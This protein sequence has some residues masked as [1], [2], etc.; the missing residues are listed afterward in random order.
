MQGSVKAASGLTFTGKSAAIALLIA[1]IPDISAAHAAVDRSPKAITRARSFIAFP[2]VEV[3]TY[4]TY[5]NLD[6]GMGV[7]S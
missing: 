1:A 5:A 3:E 2:I 7:Q 4:A 6:G